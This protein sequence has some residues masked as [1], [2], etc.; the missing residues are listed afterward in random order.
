MGGAFTYFYVATPPNSPI[1]DCGQIHNL[2]VGVFG[3]RSQHPGGVN[4]ALADGS[5]R[6]YRSEID[7]GVWRALG[8]RNGGEIVSDGE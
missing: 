7:P 8:T 1:P 2:G 4:A 5:V 6:W 3:A